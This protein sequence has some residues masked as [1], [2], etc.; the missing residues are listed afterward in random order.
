MFLICL[1]GGEACKSN[2]ACCMLLLKATSVCRLQ[3]SD[4]VP[5]EITLN[6]LKSLERYKQCDCSN[7]KLRYVTRLI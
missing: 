1:Q 7:V 4:T 6:C 2:F 3:S 5:V